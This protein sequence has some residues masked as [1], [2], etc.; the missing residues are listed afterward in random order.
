MNSRFTLQTVSATLVLAAAAGVVSAQ[1]AWKVDV[2]DFYQHQKTDPARDKTWIP[3]PLAPAYDSKDWW[4]Q[5]GGWCATAAW[6][7]AI[8][9]MED[10][11]AGIFDPS[12]RKGAGAEHKDRNWLERANYALED[13]AIIAGKRFG[14]NNGAC[15]WEPDVLAYSSNAGYADAIVDRFYL[16]G[17]QVR[18]DHNDGKSD[19]A[20][21]FANLFEA[22]AAGIDSNRAVVVNITADEKLPFW[23]A[24]SFHVMTGV[25]VDTDNSVIYVADPDS[26]FRGGGWDDGE[27]KAFER[28]YL[29]TDDYPAGDPRDPKVRDRYYSAFTIDANGVFTDGAYKGAVIE[30]VFTYIVPAPGS[31]A[32][33][34]LGG[35]AMLR[36]RRSR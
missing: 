14:I 11:F 10:R 19:N 18:R 30:S 31:L 23:W 4:E 9:S 26:T 25:A 16:S 20:T 7:N 24:R 29:A 35:G 15:A 34:G 27:D 22:F 2:P 33:V 5:G 32:L 8:A 36:R 12:R 13:L 1:T 17:K 3:K 6:T 21:G 28:R